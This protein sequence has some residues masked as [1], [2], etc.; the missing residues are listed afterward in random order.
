MALLLALLFPV[1][2]LLLVIAMEHIERSLHTGFVGDRVVDTIGDA[3][4]DAVESLVQSDAA[5]MVNRYWRRR[6]LLAR[7]RSN[8]P[9]A[10]ATGSPVDGQMD[11]AYRN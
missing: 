9:A 2:L 3:D 10:R 11:T 7:M 8:R 1:A 4:P 5:A 6:A